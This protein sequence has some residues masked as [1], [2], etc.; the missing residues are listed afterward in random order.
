MVDPRAD[1]PTI[2]VFVPGAGAGLAD[3]RQ[4]VSDEHVGALLRITTALAASLTEADVHATLVDHVAAAVSASTCALWLAHGD[5]LRLV[6]QVGYRPESQA[7]FATVPLTHAPSYPFLDAFRTCEAIWIGSTTAL[8][9]RY[10]HLG[11]ATSIGRM[12][13][14]ACL[15]LAI[16]GAVLGT[17]AMTFDEGRPASTSEQSFLLLIARYATLALQRLRVVE[18]ERRSRE[19][20]DAVAIENSRL[21]AEAEAG[22]RRAEQLYRFA[23]AAVNADSLGRVCDAGI[24][25]ILQALE[26]DRA[27]VLLF[28]DGVMRF[29]AWR[30]LSDAYRQAVEGHSPWQRDHRAPKPVL[31]S[32]CL[33]DPAWAAY[34]DV[35]RAEGIG[36]L[37]FI[38]LISR[39]ELLG[40]FMVY[41]G[42]ART[43]SVVEMEVATAISNHLASTISRFTTL[44]ALERTVRDNELFA[45]VLAHDLRNPLAAIV[46][47][48]EVALYQI[49]ADEKTRKPLT[50][51]L[52]S[53]GRMKRMIEQLLDF[54]RARVGGGIEIHRQP[55]NLSELVA[56]VAGELELVYP[57]CRFEVAPRG[58]ASGSWDPDRLAQVVSNLAGNACQHGTAGHL[59]V[60]EID[61]TQPERIQLSVHNHGE[62]PE[63]LVPQIFDPFRGGNKRYSKQSGLGLGLYI[64]SEIVRAHHGRVQVSSSSRDGTRFLVD[65]PRE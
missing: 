51:I 58:D 26:A 38:P 42:A 24:D 5:S 57:E 64:V 48:T 62:I 33:H 36:A 27:A 20:A 55:G 2:E 37:A 11:D 41:Y 14:V 40:K 23:T 25:A 4:V 61:G 46:T 39:G 13:R 44:A 34:A 63:V 52:S 53:A 45:G 65:L 17:L 56:Q 59:I 35:F 3:A 9:E 21:N 28:D 22:R 60:I 18:A 10:P 16:E 6:R 30:G 50:R 7:R 15:P 8:L 47:A 54:T 49:D 12:Y 43:F 32:D 29:K 19:R 1:I 31:V